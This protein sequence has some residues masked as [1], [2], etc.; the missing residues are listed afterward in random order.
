MPNYDFTINKGINNIGKAARTSGV[1]QPEI[2]QNMQAQIDSARVRM[3]D[4]AKAN[5]GKAVKDTLSDEEYAARFAQYKEYSN[6]H[7]NLLR[8][9]R[10]QQSATWGEDANLFPSRL[11]GKSAEDKVASMSYSGLYSPS[12]DYIA[13]N[14]LVRPN[15]SNNVGLRT[16]ENAHAL[17]DTLPNGDEGGATFKRG[18]S[19]RV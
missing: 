12:G 16:H 13:Y 1:A 8:D 5:L 2:P 14:N 15:N 7:G 17:R 4:Y 6:Q 9:A 18:I 3:M 11:R 19:N 10:V